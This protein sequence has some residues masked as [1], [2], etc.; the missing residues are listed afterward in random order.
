MLARMDQDYCLSDA[1]FTL[2][3]LA[4]YDTIE[5]LRIY[6]HTLYFD[7]IV[8]LPWLERM[9]VLQQEII[10]DKE[11]KTYATLLSACKI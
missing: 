3:I 10:T 6:R 8:D 4:A 5:E 2:S 9:Y 11:S 7:G 1:I